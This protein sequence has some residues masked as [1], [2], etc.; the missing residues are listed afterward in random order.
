MDEAW[1]GLASCFM[2]CFGACGM[3]AELILGRKMPARQIW[4]DKLRMAQKRW[5]LWGMAMRGDTFRFG[6]GIAFMA[7]QGT[8][9]AKPWA[10]FSRASAHRA[11]A[12]SG[13]H[14]D[15]YLV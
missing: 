5:L 8:S 15:G 13:V 1:E 4:Y 2:A 14:V 11:A 12:A 3:V 9:W 6:G 7:S 10:T